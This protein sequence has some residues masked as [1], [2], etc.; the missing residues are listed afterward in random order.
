[1]FGIAK[2]LHIEILAL[3]GTANHL[4]ILMAVPTSESLSNVVRDLKANSSR[5]MSENGPRFSWQEVSARLA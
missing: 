5:W 3:G 1:M 4:H 2:N